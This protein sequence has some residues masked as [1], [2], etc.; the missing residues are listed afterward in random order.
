MAR[1]TFNR[2][3]DAIEDI[4][5]IYIDCDRKDGYRYHIG[6]SEELRNDTIQNWMLSTMT[7]HNLLADN[8]SLHNRILLESIPSSD[9]HLTALTEAMKHNRKV[10]IFYQKYSQEPGRER[11]ISPFCIKLYSRRWYVLAQIDNGEM[12][13]FSLDR[14]LSL[15]PTDETF[16]LPD[17]FDAGEYFSNVIGVTIESDTK[18]ER[19]LIRAFGKEKHYLRDLPVHSSQREISRTSEH[20]D[21][22][23]HL[24]PTTDFILQLLSHGTHIQV[25]SPQWL[26]DKVKNIHADAAKIYEQ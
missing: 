23:F 10:H 8:K 13:C 9:D 20:T 22:E 17:T 21:F 14:I 5:G 4:F 18:V 2:H 15:T 25:L 7:V 16:T 11:L 26:A 6:N 12:R 24:Q 3:K 1:S 19:I